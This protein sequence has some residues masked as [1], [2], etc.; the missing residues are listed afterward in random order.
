MTPDAELLHFRRTA[1]AI[2]REAAA[3]ILAGF[4]SGTAIEKKGPIDLVTRFDREAEDLIRNRLA[5]ALPEHRIVGEEGDPQGTGERVW[6]VD[7]IDG[8]TNFAHGHPFFCVSLGLFE[9]AK[10]LVGVIDAPALGLRWSAHAGGGATRLDQA[11]RVS[12]RASLADSLCATGFAYDRWRA[13]D[14]NLAEHDAF[15]K[16]T[17][18]VRR[19]G[20]AALDLALTAEG[21]YDVYW[22]QSLKPWDLAAGLVLVQEAGGRITDYLGRPTRPEAGQV[23]ASNGLV[24]AEALATIAAAR[25]SRGLAPEGTRSR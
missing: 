17:R 11:I 3:L 1:E 21:T 9:H 5:A 10:P 23:V 7:P 2:A 4:R 12:E 24:H 16:S 22:E 19:C 20:S 6:F 14:D 15:V 13:V 18:G 8:T 25:A